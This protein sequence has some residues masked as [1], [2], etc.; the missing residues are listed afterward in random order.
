MGYYAKLEDESLLK[1][2]VNRYIR[3]NWSKT[4][5]PDLGVAYARKNQALWHRYLKYCVKIGRINYFKRIG[6]DTRFVVEIGSCNNQQLYVY[7][8]DFLV[9]TPLGII[10]DE[11]ASR[12]EPLRAFLLMKKINYPIRIIEDNF[13]K[14]ISKVYKEHILIKREFDER[15]NSLKYGYNLL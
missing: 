8:L 10:Y 11:I 5:Y 7:Y 14:E 4:F 3:R 12:S 1:L 13:I 9:S 2:R 6:V 15:Y